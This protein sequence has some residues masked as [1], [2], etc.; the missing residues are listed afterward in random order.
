MVKNMVWLKTKE[1]T[2]AGVG[3]SVTFGILPCLTFSQ[4]DF[5]HSVDQCN[6]QTHAASTL[7]P[8]T[9]WWSSPWKSMDH[10]I[11]RRLVGFP[12]ILDARCSMLF[13]KGE[14]RNVPKGFG[15]TISNQNCP[16]KSCHE[17]L[18]PTATFQFWF[19]FEFE[20]SLLRIRTSQNFT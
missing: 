3:V 18:A 8:W 17:T 14:T 12:L 7:L 5:C 13:W 6:E 9:L 2:P 15:R 20:S 19:G 16:K 11:E 4:D 1:P 10:L